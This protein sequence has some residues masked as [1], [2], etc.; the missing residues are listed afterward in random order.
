M[1]D[2]INRTVTKNDQGDVSV[3]SGYPTIINLYSG[4][5]AGIVPLPSSIPVG[6]S[7]YVDR[8]LRSTIY[9]ESMWAGAVR[10]A[11]TKEVAR[12]FTCEDNG[13][14][15]RKE[16]AQE[17]LL[18]SDCGQGWVQFCEKLLRD[19]IL[20]DNGAFVEI[21]RATSARGSRIIGLM[22]L[23]SSRCTRT[24]DPDYPIIY[25][26]LAGSEHAMRDYQV[27]TFSD[28]P[29]SDLSYFGVG[30][31]SAHAAYATIYKLAGLERYFS[32]KITGSRALSLKFIKGMNKIT[33]D[34]AILTAEA[35]ASAKGYSVFM[36]NI[37]VP[38][39][40][41][42]PLELIDVPL[43]DVPDG[44]DPETERKRADVIYANC[45][46]VPL[47]DLQPLSGQGLGTGTQSIILAEESEGYGLS[48]WRRDWIHK[49]NTHVFPNATTFA[50]ANTN[51]LRDRK[52][53]A[54]VN[55]IVSKTYCDL[56]DKGIITPAQA[57][58][59][60][61]DNKV[62]PIEFVPVDE[63]PDTSLDDDEK[64]PDLAEIAAGAAADNAAM[65]PQDALR[66]KAGDESIN[67]IIA[68]A[69]RRIA[70]LMKEL[71]A[72]NM[73]ASQWSSGMMD[74]ISSGHEQAYTA[75][76]PAGARANPQIVKRAITEQNKYL[77]KFADEISNADAY[78]PA[79]QPR[80]NMYGESIKASY[81]RGASA[82]LPIPAIPGDG[83][84][85]C[86]TNCR[87]S[88]D[89]KML[90]GTDNAD[91]YWRYG[92]TEDHCQSCIERQSQ[93]SPLQ[94]RDGVLL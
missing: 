42:I 3:G 76:L 57:L 74:I 41:E 78:N 63:T 9:H 10:K 64:A 84:T 33:L 50:F 2:V 59:L 38:I 17:L 83:T 23:P 12:G 88:L 60:L 27:L 1:P 45:L 89:I 75:G 6:W 77:D 62:I 68:R 80:A 93:W 73:S 47:Q 72:G 53:I 79:W 29:R 87:C 37:I 65:A 16:R 26:D 7:Q 39:P 28:M 25:R 5:F 46:G 35:G 52:A 86:L 18:Q 51:D 31:C 8:I 34:N 43:A 54:D 70:A 91:V 49:I 67:A 94:I 19:F 15:R 82:G 69:E 4:E 40:G 55:A 24:G 56:V 22:H 92:D 44:F 61:A 71:A 85:Q 81:W 36:G 13:S 32:E 90:D 66:V 30:F 11:I 20:T 58:Q 48:A 21:V 14:N